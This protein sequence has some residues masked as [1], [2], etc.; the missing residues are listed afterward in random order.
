MASLT[1]YIRLSL[2]ADLLGDEQ[3]RR[4]T[5]RVHAILTDNWG[6]LTGPCADESTS[7]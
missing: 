6:L 5:G 1:T 2:L 4:S 7:T 3:P